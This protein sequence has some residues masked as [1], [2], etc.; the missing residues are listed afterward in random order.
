MASRILLIGTARWAATLRRKYEVA[1]A[2]SGLQAKLYSGQRFSLI[3]IDAASMYVSGE[4]ICRDVKA[5]FPDS[6]LLLISASA[7]AASAASA[8][9]TLRAPLTAR[10]LTTAVSRLL[11]ADP[12]D[13]IRCG[14]FTLNR[15]A[16]FLQAHGRQAPLS[17]KLAGLIELF[18]SRPNETL[19]RADIMRHVWKTAYLDDTRTL[20]VHIRHARKL[21]ETDPRKPAY[22][23]TV[24]GI[25]YRFEVALEKI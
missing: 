10:A 21:L 19:T 6:T 18:M 15:R 8:D 14:P 4:R 25:G 16:R 22:L 1:R 13:V 12:N 5:R 2:R 9:I 23:R 11:T 17:P 24:R 20:N 3:V 7:N